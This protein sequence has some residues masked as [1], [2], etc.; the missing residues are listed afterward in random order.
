M[1]FIF[2][3]SYFIPSFHFSFILFIVLYPDVMGNYLLYPDVWGN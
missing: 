3:F 1:Y 2:I